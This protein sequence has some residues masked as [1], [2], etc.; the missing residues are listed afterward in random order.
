MKY[1]IAIILTIALAFPAFALAQSSSFMEFD[2]AEIVRADTDHGTVYHIQVRLR[3]V[4]EVDGKKMK[5]SNHRF[6]LN[7]GETDVPAV[8]RKQFKTPNGASADEAVGILDALAKDVFTQKVKNNWAAKVAADQA[9]ME[10]E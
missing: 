2:R 7:P 3:S 4:A 8:V 9:E 6:V 1:I 10:A 5:I